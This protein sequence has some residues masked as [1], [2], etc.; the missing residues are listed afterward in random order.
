MTKVHLI[1][2][3]HLDPVWLWRWTEGC[4]E[5]LSTFRSALDRL[6]EYPDYV[7]T[8]AGAQYY[9][10]VERLDPG[11]FEEIRARVAEGRW[12]ITGGWRI[13]PDCNLPSAESFAR[14]AL[15]SQRYYLEKF[16]RTARVGYNV[17]SFGHSAALPQLLRLSGLSAYVFMR[18]SLPDEKTFPFE[19]RSFLWKG[20]DGTC[21]PTYRVPEPY[22]SRPFEEAAEKA[23]AEARLAKDQPVMSFYGVG[24]HGGGP[25]RRN[26]DA[27]D[28]LIA[29]SAPGEYGYSSP[30]RFFE[31]LDASALPALEDEL[32]HHASG[33]YSALS[34]IKRLNR[35]AEERLG[36][37][38]KYLTLAQALGYPMDFSPIAR[39]WKIV[40]FHQFHDVMG[41]CIIRDAYEDAVRALGGAVF[42]ADE[43]ANQAL[44]TIAWHIN[45]GAPTGGKVEGL[46]WTGEAGTPLSLFNPTA[47]EL[48]VP[49]RSGL[50]AAVVRDEAGNLVPS[51]RARGQ[52]TNGD[53]DKWETV[54][55]ARIPALGW[56]T[57]HLHRGEGR[58]VE[59]QSPKAWENDFV[60]VEFGENGLPSRL[61]DKRSGR[62]LLRAPVSLQVI[63][64]TA[65]DTWA[66]RVFTFDQA[67]GQFTLEA[68]DCEQQGEVFVS[69][70]AR[71]RYGDSTALVTM[72]LYR[73][74]PELH[75]DVQVHWREAHRLL[76]LA[77]PT[78]FAG[79][80]EVA[81]IPGGF[82]DRRADGKEQPMQGWVCLGGLGAASDAL[83]AYSARDGEVR[84]TLLRSPLFADH[85]GA[86][87]EYCEAT[88]QGEHRIRLALTPETEPDRLSALS[89][90]LL[91]PPD[92][93]L[94]SF[95]HGNLP[96]VYQGLRAPAHV[97]LDAFKPAED[98]NGFL[99]RLRSVSR[100][101]LT[102]A[103][104]LPA[105]KADIPLCL[106]P[107]QNLTLRSS[108]F[109]RESD[110]IET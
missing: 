85:F 9:E 14:Q 103:L 83:T 3:A 51:Q 39:A 48:V 87:D 57:Y 38:E 89:A 25:T 23:Q 30:D 106:R 26:L 6:N 76:K 72:T 28:A 42:A 67:V 95:H 50:D 81:S 45:T 64:E 11:M 88:G 100:E 41:G 8:C 56:R 59:A 4:S 52:V 18:P 69:R 82:Y 33:C 101:P 92:R 24:N 104:C 20:A 71:L 32:L 43:A 80:G 99:L 5:V 110:F 47:Q 54:F 77:L 78:P 109:W 27:L 40:C 17:D 90:S 34:Q 73:G 58:P 7:F 63:D 98:G 79:E 46:L 36:A 86:R 37:A 60:R 44:Q 65:C 105:L 49:V 10:W 74:L 22:C 84:L 16:G 2:N 55:L 62:E 75:L 94:G 91:C 61:L 1:G 93:V 19:E 96:E 53:H 108:A 102:G 66:H 107:Q 70:R 13:Q 97:I 35:L 21:I 15:Y 29:Q 12:V 31:E 68:I